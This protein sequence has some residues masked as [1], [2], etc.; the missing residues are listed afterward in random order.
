MF[1]AMSPPTH[2]DIALGVIKSVVHLTE[3]S[4]E[5]TLLRSLQASILEML[6]GALA[7]LICLVPAP[8]RAGWILDDACALPNPM[9]PI[10][11]W[12]R[13]GAGRLGG[14]TPH[15]HITR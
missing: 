14:Q 13:T 7:S 15:P 10:V 1:V 6:P 8:E 3:Q 5:L 12:L 11:D 4:D 2:S 9:F